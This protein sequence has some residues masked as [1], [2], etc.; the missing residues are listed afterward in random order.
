MRK[1][2]LAFCTFLWLA[3]PTVA[4]PEYIPNQ[5]LIQTRSAAD[6]H[7]FLNSPPS[8][9]GAEIDV[10][11]VR[12]VSEPL[13]IHLV[14]F[15]A[16]TGVSDEMVLRAVRSHPQIPLAQF[17]HR[18]SQRCTEFNDPLFENQWHH[19]NTGQ[20]GTIA[21]ADIDS[22]FA[23][24]ITTGGTTYAGD[25]IVVCVIEGGDLNHPDLAANAW[26]NYGEIP[27]NGIDDDGNGYVDDYLG[28]NVNSH[29]D[30]GV[31]EGSHGTGVMGMIGAVGNNELGIIG[32]NHRV[33]LM[34]VAGES[35]SDEASVVEAYTYPLVMRKLYNDT[36]GASG[37][38]VVA[39]NASWGINFGNPDDV[40]LW[41]AVYDSLG[42]VG[43]LNCVATA[44]NNVNVDQVGDI[45]SAVE[46]ESVVA[47][48]ATNSQDLR[49]FSAWGPTSVDLAAP[50]QGVLTTDAT[51]YG[52]VSGTSFASPLTAGVIGLLYS[53]PC[54]D[55]AGDALENPEA[56]AY[57]IKQKILDGVDPI[58]SLQGMTVTGGRL[59]A[60]NSLF[61]LMSDCS[62]TPC[63]KPLAL[64]HQLIG[65]SV[66]TLSWTH[67]VSTSVDI[68]FKTENDEEWVEIT[69]YTGTSLVLDTLRKCV[70]YTFEVRNTCD[71]V[72]DAS[73]CVEFE[74]KGCCLAPLSHEFENVTEND[75]VLTWTPS[76]GIY[77][78]RVDYREEGAGTWQTWGVTSQNHAWIAGLQP[79]TVYDFCISPACATNPNY[80]RM[81]EASTAGCG[82]CQDQ[83]YCVTGGE[84]SNFAHIEEVEFGGQSF[85]IGSTAGYVYMDGE[86]LELP[87]GG[88][89]ALAL[90][91]GIP[92][93]DYDKAVGVWLD[94][95][96]DGEFS[97]DES[98]FSAVYAAGEPVTEEIAI[99]A[100]AP[101]GP[102]R[103][104][105]SMKYVGDEP[106]TGTVSSCGEF[107]YG[108]TVD[109][110]AEIIGNVGVKGFGTLWGWLV[111][112]NPTTG[113]VSLYSRSTEG[114]TEATFHL[115]DVSGRQVHTVALD[116]Q[117]REID[118]SDLGT[119]IYFYRVVSAGIT[120]GTGKIVRMDGADR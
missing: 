5:L 120:V 43:I 98:L 112:P 80:G 53:A 14:E 39:T 82:P 4:Q 36:Q 27:G 90:T 69:D 11:L 30:Q 37:A 33:K 13:G 19:R 60:F 44:N 57:Y 70:T 64:T 15:S 113:K 75:L 116:A 111:H 10:D 23:W 107:E 58:S 118:L 103:L 21:D 3:L 34:S 9:N 32:A 78:H 86:W 97:E 25:T 77:S 105:I 102:A 8:I 59:N 26:R 6:M 119:G 108:Q 104:R 109:F 47:V 96:G 114:L 93:G 28:W 16:P 1:F 42:A 83:I 52:A 38:F 49:T 62:Q 35:T 91:P 56:T 51:G 84:S 68:R 12:T 72:D 67:L 92:F 29:D 20:N 45:P 76:F 65:D 31:L 50:G 54:P 88:T 41:S 110:C 117:T 87:E 95:D 55:I 71:E 99:P 73:T 101:W 17:N 85:S 46:A 81:A 40:P 66:H 79:C 74:T 22:D 2:F 89:V 24:D 106:G 61:D 7:A 18:I 115:H 100:G 94:A 63:S 48:T